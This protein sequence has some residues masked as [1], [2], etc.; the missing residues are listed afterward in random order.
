[1]RPMPFAMKRCDLTGC[2][3]MAHGVLSDG[4]YICDKHMLLFGMG[5][6]R[7][8]AHNEEEERR[9]A[10]DVLEELE[11]GKFMPGDEDADLKPH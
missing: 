2:E 9:N 8:E 4:R 6:K 1:M 10:P 11:E 5:A 3:R 7:V